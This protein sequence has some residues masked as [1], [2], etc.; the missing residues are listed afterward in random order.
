MANVST[1][2]GFSQRQSNKPLSMIQS[3]VYDPKLPLY[4]RT[5]QENELGHLGALEKH[6]CL[7][8][9]SLTTHPANIK[10]M[11]CCTLQIFSR[12]NHILSSLMFLSLGNFIS[13]NLFFLL[14]FIF[15]SDFVF[16][17]KR[18]FTFERILYFLILFLNFLSIFFLLFF[19][20][21][22]FYSFETTFLMFFIILELC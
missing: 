18:R 20:S 13:L 16:F 11:K 22:S 15:F 19:S 21:F 9:S 4:Y 10:R 3:P 5:K 6:N 2:W 12:N 1:L 7:L 17:F 14:R 8:T